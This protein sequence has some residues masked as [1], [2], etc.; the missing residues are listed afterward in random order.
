LDRRPIVL[1]VDDT[2]ANL[3]VLVETLGDAYEIAVAMDGP[4]A[5]QAVAENRPDIILLDIMMPGM[6]GHEVCRRLKADPQSA[7]IP[8][9]FIT[10]MAEISDEAKGFELGAVDYITKPISPPIVQARVAT[11]LSLRKAYMDLARQHEELKEYAR[12]RDDVERMSR[13][14]LKTPL[15]AVITVPQMIL[16]EAQLTPDQRDLLLLLKQSGYRMLQL[17]NSSLDLYKLETGRYQLN[18]GPVDLLP[19]LDQIDGEL[20][21]LMLGGGQ[22]IRVLVN[23][24]PPQPGQGFFVTGEEMLLYTMLANLVKN[25]VEAS[26]ENQTVTV[27]LGSNHAASIKIHNQGTV[28]ALVRERFFEKFATAGKQGGTGLGTHTARL[29]AQTLGGEI[30][31]TS[32]DETGTTVSIKLELAAP[33]TPPTAPRLQETS[34]PHSVNLAQ[35]Y[36]DKAHVLQQHLHQTH[37]PGLDACILIVDDYSNMRSI[38]KSVLLR[39]G[40]S[41]ILEARDGEKALNIIRS[42]KIDLVISDVNMPKMSGLEL[43][44]A[45]RNQESIAGVPFIII[46]GEAD[47]NT[48]LAAAKAKVSAYL[49]KPFSPDGLKA[50]I[51]KVLPAQRL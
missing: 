46:T 13:H 49:L 2:E 25:A 18:P 47:K 4:T 42:S 40:Y 36:T 20:G 12:L 48:V 5:L 17:I 38:T 21:E 31:F 11:H 22:Q 29:I 41:D 9:V 37:Q 30:G 33:L 1:V 7:D 35:V 32:S 28:P 10:A 51:E 23:D 8:V 34:E 43:L 26:P 24:G 15:N 50:K 6:D 45:V 44:N 27:H 14:D 16:E 39:M 19:L 3:D